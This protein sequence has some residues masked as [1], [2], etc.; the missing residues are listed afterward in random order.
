MSGR[1][2]VGLIVLNSGDLPLV[3][4]SRSGLPTPWDIEDTKEAVENQPS[5]STRRMS[6]SFGPSKDTVH[7]HLKSLDQ[8]QAKL[9]FFSWFARVRFLQSPEDIDDSAVRWATS[10]I[11][12]GYRDSLSSERYR[13]LFPTR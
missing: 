3:D 12:I 7:R 8:R 11:R 2:T 5:T 10:G 6:N 9:Y 1:H 4:H 13:R